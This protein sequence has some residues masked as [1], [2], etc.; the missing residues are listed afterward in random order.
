MQTYSGLIRNVTLAH[1][2]I[3]HKH[4]YTRQAIVNKQKEEYRT[5]VAIR[6]QIASSEEPT[7]LR[8]GKKIIN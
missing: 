7:L 3:V 2:Y 1:A 5:P 6:K 4:K 8:S